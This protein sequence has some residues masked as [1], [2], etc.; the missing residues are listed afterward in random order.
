MKTF[1][2]SDNR[3]ALVP[4]HWGYIGGE[5]VQGKDPEDVVRK[6][7]T[8]SWGSTGH[9]RDFVMYVTDEDGTIHEFNVV[10]ETTP[11]FLVEAK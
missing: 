4:S 8:W 5:E 1:R 9:E 11:V 2:V 3:A 7:L 10:V 6:W